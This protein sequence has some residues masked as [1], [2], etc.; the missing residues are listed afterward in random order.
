[1]LQAVAAEYILTAPLA[2]TEGLE[3][4]AEEVHIT[5]VLEVLE[6]QDKEITVVLV[7]VSLVPEKFLVAAAAAQVVQLP[8]NLQHQHHL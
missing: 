5:V 7:R 6:R 4:Q 3:V 8:I 2:E 1:V